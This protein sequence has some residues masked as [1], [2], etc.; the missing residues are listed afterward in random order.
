MRTIATISV[1]VGVLIASLG[2]SALAVERQRPS[3]TP[4]PPTR[5]KAVPLSTGECEQLGG[6][7]L[8]ETLCQGSLKA[9]K[10]VDQYGHTHRVCITTTAP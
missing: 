5:T 8:K 7:V 6:T 4:T 3:P 9:C 10:T 1:T 2:T